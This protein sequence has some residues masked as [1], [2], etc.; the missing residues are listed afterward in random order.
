VSRRVVFDTS[1]VL[2]AL[3]FQGGRLSWLRQHWQ[4]GVCQ[5]LASRATTL[6]LTRVLTYPKFALS[7]EDRRELLAEYLPYCRIIE[8]VRKCP[9]TCR[10]TKD[11]PFLDLAHSAKAELLITGDRDLL[12]LAGQ[13]LFRIVTPEAYRQEFQRQMSD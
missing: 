10:D 11:Q 8:Q 13:S 4:E 5:P 9:V 7:L 12:V 3:L 2:S 6:E 1:T